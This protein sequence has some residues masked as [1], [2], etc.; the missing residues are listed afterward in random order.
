MLNWGPPAVTLVY[1][2]EL[3]AV[4][5]SY[6]VVSLF[7]QQPS[8]AGE[9]EQPE[10]ITLPRLGWSVVPSQIDL[11][12]LP[13]IRTAN[14]RRAVP[15]VGVLLFG[16]VLLGPTLVGD[17][18]VSEAW[19]PPRR[20]VELSAFLSTAT[21]ALSPT[22]AAAAGGTAVAQVAATYRRFVASGVYRQSSAYA[23]LRRLIRF[24][25]LLGAIGV[26][27]VV[28]VVVALLL[29]GSVPPLVTLL[30]VFCL[31]KLGLERERSRGETDDDRSLIASFLVPAAA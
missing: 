3:T 14:V 15:T 17:T 31:L 12:S 1:V 5:V 18:S 23:I 26:A 10:I 4:A 6:G 8:D 13:P 27:S 7:A 19:G 20:A 11:P 16:V 28:C 30:A 24:T 29:V 2:T 22:V 21:G 9:G 25:L